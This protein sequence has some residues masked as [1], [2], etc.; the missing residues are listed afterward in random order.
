MKRNA[1]C[2][3]CR[4]VRI[5]VRFS[6]AWYDYRCGAVSRQPDTDPVSGRKAWSDEDGIIRDDKHPYCRDVNRDGS[7]ELFS[8]MR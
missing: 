4:H 1:I 3:K 6:P 7:C 2:A 8:E 5:A